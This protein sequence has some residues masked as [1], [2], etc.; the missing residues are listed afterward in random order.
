MA[1]LDVLAADQG[2]AQSCSRGMALLALMERTGYSVVQ[3]NGQRKYGGPPPGGFCRRNTAPSPPV[4]LSGVCEGLT[5]CTRLRCCRMGGAA[6]PAGLR[7][8]CGEAAA[9]HVRGR[10]GAAA[11][12]RWHHLRVP[13]DDG[14][15]WGQPRLRLCHVHQQ[16][17]SRPPPPCKRLW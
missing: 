6:A 8:L 16:V 5:Y 1:K 15:Q 11:G 14:V 2:F 17:R 3:E 9:G 10:A 12:E 4:L 7:G 13:A